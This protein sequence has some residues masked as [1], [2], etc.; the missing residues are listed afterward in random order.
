MLPRF[1]FEAGAL[2]CFSFSLS[3]FALLTPYLPQGYFL[4]EHLGPSLTNGNQTKA[5]MAKLVISP[6][7]FWLSLQPIWA[8]I[9]ALPP[10]FLVALDLRT[11]RGGGGVSLVVSGSICPLIFFVSHA[12][13]L[14]FT[15][16]SHPLA[17]DFLFP[18]S[19]WGSYLKLYFVSSLA[20]VYN[21]S[22][23]CVLPNQTLNIP[24]G[25][26]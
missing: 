1:S 26:I 24:R 21:I 4:G 8:F 15:L 6:F 19:V 20:V 17:K 2:F 7:H 5:V 22:V 13:P 16:C 18:L 9:I 3:F 14:T 10:P 25:K 23:F 11:W 12:S